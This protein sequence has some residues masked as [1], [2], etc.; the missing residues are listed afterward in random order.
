[1]MLE[2]AI[3]LIVANIF[4][5]LF[6]KFKQPGVV[7]EIFTGI[8]LGPS[9]IGQLSGSSLILYDTSVFSFNLDLG[10]PEFKELA[11]IGIIFLLFIIGLETNISDLKRNSKS[12]FSTALFGLII[13]FFFGFIIGYIFNIDIIGCMAIGAIFFATSLTISL[14]ILSDLSKLSS[15]VGLTIQT[16]GIISDVV[17][18]FIFSLIIGQGNPL[19]FLLR[20]LIF[21]AFIVCLGMIIIRYSLKKGVSQH[22]MMMIFPFSII[23]CFLMAAFAED[24]GLA[25]ILGAFAAGLIFKRTPHVG[26]ILNS[27]K[28][29][30]HYFFI[31]LFFVWIGASF[32]LMY[33][34]SS[35]QI[36]TQMLFFVFF[37]ILG[38]SGN[39]F[40]STLGA[41]IAGL[42]KKESYSVGIGMIPVM[43][44]SLIIVTTEID[45]GIFGDPSGW[46]AQQIKTATL[47]LI[48]VSNL[49]TPPLLK[50]SFSGAFMRKK[51]RC[52]LRNSLK[53]IKS[54]F[55]P[56][57]DVQSWLGFS[58]SY[59]MFL[60]K[61]LFFSIVFQFF[62]LLS[63]KVSSDFISFV[64]AIGGCVLGSYIGY[65]TL[66]YLKIMLLNLLRLRL[67]R[68]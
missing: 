16:A 21:F 44:M 65:V 30:G 59:H 4:R 66:K 57:T 38:I 17:G 41:R 19:I 42:S 52:W 28:M 25:A 32:N 55:I 7:G 37:I 14:R 20:V 22:S 56:G 5:Y 15:K 46:M 40:G 13:P 2:I 3:A 43:G 27:V 39:F 31:P 58:D 35:G 6:E 29:I 60:R 49:V 63:L 67:P 61:I 10:S 26:M 36:I 47:L 45:R 11:F 50:K 23:M 48:I 53:S 62:L 8:L 12:G 34:L 9:L 51:Q 54:F 68:S 64:A 1:M 18:L 24:M 33:V